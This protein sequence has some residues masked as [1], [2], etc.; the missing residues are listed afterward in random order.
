[1][2]A[3]GSEAWGASCLT[4]DAEVEAGY[5]GTG[6]GDDDGDAVAVDVMADNEHVVYE[7]VGDSGYGSRNP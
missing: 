6:D 5:D 3:G 7:Y 2:L 1:M 4:G